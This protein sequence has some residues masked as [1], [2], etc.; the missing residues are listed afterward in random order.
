MSDETLHLQPGADIGGLLLRCRLDR[1]WSRREAARQLVV[2]PASIRAWEEL[3]RM[4]STATLS[5]ILTV[6]GKTVTIGIKPV[7]GVGQ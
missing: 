5:H 3:E 4:P 6:Y 1:G 2:N 7:G